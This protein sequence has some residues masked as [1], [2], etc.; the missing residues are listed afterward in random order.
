MYNKVD[1]V[2]NEDVKL[3]TKEYLDPK[4]AVVV[5]ETCKENELVWRR[6]VVLEK[7]RKNLMKKKN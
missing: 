7:L 4:K 6:L 3:F 2:M 1:K 5:I